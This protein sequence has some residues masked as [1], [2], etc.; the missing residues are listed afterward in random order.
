MN[1][2]KLFIETKP[3]MKSFQN[4]IWFVTLIFCAPVLYVLNRFY[5]RR[6]HLHCQRL[7]KAIAANDP[8][9]S[10]GVCRAASL[11]GYYYYAAKYSPPPC[12]RSLYMEVAP[13]PP[14]AIHTQSLM[15]SW[16]H[17]TLYT[18]VCKTYYICYPS[19]SCL[20]TVFS[21]KGPIGQT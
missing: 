17:Q 14:E 9:T 4:Q 6:R 15:V 12:Y 10:I 8:R 7:A 13:G 2:T 5:L 20:F 11:G 16:G 18:Y 21:K 3:F 19:V 1:I